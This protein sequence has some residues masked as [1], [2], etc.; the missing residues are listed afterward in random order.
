MQKLE[1]RIINQILGV[2]G[3]NLQ[4]ETSLQ[5]LWQIFI[6]VCHQSTSY[7]QFLHRQTT[8]VFVVNN[9]CR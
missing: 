7:V 5:E 8:H 6:P 3:L 2:K 1:G 4:T 9:C